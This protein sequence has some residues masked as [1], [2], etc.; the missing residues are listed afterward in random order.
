MLALIAKVF[1]VIIVNHQY[2]RFIVQS[3]TVKETITSILINIKG[4]YSLCKIIIILYNNLECAQFVPKTCTIAETLIH[5]FL[6]L[7]V[8][9]LMSITR[10][11]AL[12]KS[13]LNNFKNSEKNHCNCLYIFRIFLIYQIYLGILIN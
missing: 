8:V 9:L 1:T 2:H 7:K 3:L 12:L 4:Q 13:L 5:I 11:Q 10:L 6:E